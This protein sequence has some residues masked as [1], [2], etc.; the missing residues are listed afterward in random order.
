MGRTR[1]RTLK[2]RTSIPD[3]ARRLLGIQITAALQE[4]H[5]RY[6][7]NRGKRSRYT[8]ERACVTTGIPFD[9]MKSYTDG[10]RQPN[11]LDMREL[12]VFT[13]VSFMEFMKI[14]PNR[15]E[16]DIM[17]DEERKR[18]FAEAKANRE[19]EPE[20]EDEWDD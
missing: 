1:G 12:C 14:I 5:V 6:D 10:K 13:G 3:E 19:K 11:I 4:E 2:R 20:E 15:R 18:V 7:A 8:V 16:L 17:Y 9:T